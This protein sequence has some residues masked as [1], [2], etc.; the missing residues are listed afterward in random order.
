[1]REI[2]LDTETTGLDPLDGH[3]IIEIGCIELMNHVPTGRVFH[4]YLNPGR[5]IDAGAQA[6]TGI[7]E[8]MLRDKPPFSQ[9]VGDFLEF[10]DGAPLVIHN[11]SFDLAFL[12]AELKR[13]DHPPIYSERAIDTLAITKRKFPGAPASLDALC[14]RFS[15][16]LTVRDKHGALLDAQLLAQVY[17]E[18]IGGRQ[19]NLAL[20]ED[21]GMSAEISIVPHDRQPQRPTPLQSFITEDEL[22]AHAAF[23]KTLRGEV[24]W[25]S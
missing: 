25:A 10:I 13:T 14:R 20:L 22:V 17:L 16:D 1:M 3:R 4:H 9:I 5:A 15:V 23:I 19:A 8:E 18:L 24:L 21:G 11:A 7:T 12:N 2:V 6:V